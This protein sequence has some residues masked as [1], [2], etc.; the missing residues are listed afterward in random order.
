MIHQKADASKSQ[1]HQ[2]NWLKQ[3]AE[4]NKILFVKSW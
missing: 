1:H 4:K 2:E 3:I